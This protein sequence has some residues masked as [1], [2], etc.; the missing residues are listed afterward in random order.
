M[1]TPA[2]H[3]Q[4]FA[5]QMIDTATIVIFRSQIINVIHDSVGTP[6]AMAARQCRN[7]N[8]GEYKIKEDTHEIPFPAEILVASQ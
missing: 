8:A 4:L 3:I 2:G 5:I 6:K 7:A 1:H